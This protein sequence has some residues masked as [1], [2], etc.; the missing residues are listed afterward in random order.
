MIAAQAIEIVRLQV[1]VRPALAREQHLDDFFDVF[2]TLAERRQ[3]H[4]DHGQ[5]VIK[6]ATKRSAS[7]F[8]GKLAMSGRHDAHVVT[9][10]MTA[11]ESGHLAGF[12]HA[13][14]LRLKA[15][16]QIA[17]L[18]EEQRAAV[19]ELERAGAV[20]VGTGV[21]ALHVA[22]Q[23]A[24]D[25]RLARSAAVEDDE[26]RFA[27]RAVLVDGARGELLACPALAEKKNRRMRGAGSLEHGVDLP[28]RRA[29][30]HERAERAA[31]ARRNE[32]RLFGG[33]ELEQGA[34]H[35]EDRADWNLGFLQGNAV[36]QSAV[37]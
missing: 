7:D 26:R 33:H 16:G 20:G 32:N 6:I 1:I 9:L 15:D 5:A 19:G 3:M 34:A 17:D 13:Q 22:E 12:E 8:F 25:Q 36:E 27:P 21:G 10:G 37:A 24:F 29:G 31:R 23:I 30:A 4:L 18:V 14:E 28:H 35:F 2:E 11:A